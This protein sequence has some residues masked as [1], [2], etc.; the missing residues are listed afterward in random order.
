[1]KAEIQIQPVGVD[2]VGRFFGSMRI[3]SLTDWPAVLQLASPY[4]VCL[5]VADGTTETTDELST[6]ASRALDQGLVYLCAWGDGCDVVEDIVDWAFIARPDSSDRPIVV[7]TSHRDVP[8]EAAV[9]FFVKDAVPVDGY[10][11]ACSTWLLVEVGQA[12]AMSG[13]LER[14]VSVIA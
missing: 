9:D 4:F 8:V 7:T 10:G 14:L 2:P 1:M 6:W 5:V 11:S 3:P 13:A 12:G